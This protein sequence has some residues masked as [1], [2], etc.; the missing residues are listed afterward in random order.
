M[1]KKLTLFVSAM[2]HLH[3][4]FTQ[5]VMI[6]HSK[7][8]IVIAWVTAVKLGL[9]SAILNVSLTLT[10]KAMDDIFSATAK[11]RFVGAGATSRQ[12][13]YCGIFSF[14]HPS[15]IPMPRLEPGF[16]EYYDFS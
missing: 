7:F 1:K 5:V 13:R 9:S 15:I 10:R 12:N 4:L 11:I 14:T 3:T 8:V 16:W 2:C 6:P